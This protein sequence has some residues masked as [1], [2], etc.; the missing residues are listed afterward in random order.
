V[1]RSEDLPV[2]EETPRD[3]PASSPSA[4]ISIIIPT[5]NEAENIAK[6]LASTRGAPDVEVILVDGG[7]SDQTVE[8]ARSCGAEVIISP[9]GRA[10][11]MNAGAAI[12]KGEVLLFLHGD[13]RL[14]DGRLTIPSGSLV[15]RKAKVSEEPIG[16][17]E[18]RGP[19]RLTGI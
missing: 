17:D 18:S 7:S 12:A 9:A 15:W 14:L 11:Q 4:R 3:E 13:S 1:A 2:W 5:L 10:R 6:T 19:G 8:M 16:F